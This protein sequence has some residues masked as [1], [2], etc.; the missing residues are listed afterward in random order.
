MGFLGKVRMKA[1]VFIHI[2]FCGTLLNVND[3]FT[4][5]FLKKLALEEVYLRD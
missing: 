1:I 4:C 3:S 5:S 2:V